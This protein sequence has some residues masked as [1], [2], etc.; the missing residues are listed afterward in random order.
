MKSSITVRDRETGTLFEEKV[1]GKF[2]L[3][4]VYGTSFVSRFLAFLSAKFPAASKLYGWLQKQP[5]SQKKILP[6]LEK[7]NVDASEFALKPIEYT[8]FNDFFIRELKAEVRPLVS[9]PNVAVFPADARYL[10][11][12]DLSQ[13][14]GFYIKGKG[15]SVS[16]LLQQKESDYEAGSMVIARLCPTD[17]HRFHFPMDCIPGEAKLINGPLYSVNPIALRKHIEIL[18][19]NKRMVTTLQ[20]DAFGD[21]LFVEVGATCVGS[22]HQTYLSNSRCKKGEEKGYFEFGGSC[23]ILLFKPGV[24]QFDTDLIDS[25]KEFIEMRGKLGQRLGESLL[26]MGHAST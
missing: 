10:V 23:V 12:P 13:V 22:I 20:T 1:Y 21:V 24:I 15:F 25:S 11:F 5:K 8:S 6:F 3:E 16:T 18:N 17:Y 26:Q 14:D 9:G 4:L 19:E 2:F 7:F